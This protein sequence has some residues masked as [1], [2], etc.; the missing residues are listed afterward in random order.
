MKEEIGSDFYEIKNTRQNAE[1]QH[2]FNSADPNVF[3]ALAGRTALDF[4]I[5]DISKRKRIFNVFLPSYCCESMIVPFLDNHINVFFYNVILTE[6]GVEIE[7]DEISCADA[8]VVMNYF[9]FKS[10]FVESF[11]DQ[12]NQKNIIVI[13]DA[14]QS[15]F[16]EESYDERADYMFASFRKWM[17]I[18]DGSILAKRDGCFNISVPQETKTSYLKKRTKA[19][20]LKKEYLDKGTGNKNKY[21]SKFTEASCLLN[22]DYEGYR[23]SDCSIRSLNNN[24]FPSIKDKRQKNARFLINALLNQNGIT[25]PFKWVGENDVPLF[26][27]I[28]VQ[29]GF[30]NLL[31]KHLIKQRI[32]CP[33][34]WPLFPEHKISQKCKTVYGKEL[35]LVCDQRYDIEDMRRIAEELETFLTSEREPL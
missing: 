24:D 17:G 31:R 27:P 26:V 34:H 4:I 6:N 20:Q 7:A 2:F 21:L 9:G 18:P 25:L 29:G 10:Q 13:K 1:V 23:M 33:V 22:Q 14:T 3:Y 32:Y 16:C 5:K 19:M 12:L 28:L 15:L 11:I 35:S 8:V 30:R